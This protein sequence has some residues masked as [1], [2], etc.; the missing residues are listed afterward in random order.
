MLTPLIP[1]TFVLGYIGDLAYGSKLHRIH[2]EAEMI[3][4]YEKALLDMPTG[5]PTVASIDAARVE[6]DEERFVGRF[7][8][9]DGQGF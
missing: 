2:A 7:A 4:E 3:M 5:L 6:L 8:Y 1:M 9:N